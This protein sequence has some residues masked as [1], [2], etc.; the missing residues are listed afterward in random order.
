[1]VVIYIEV[2]NLLKGH[3]IQVMAIPSLKEVM[4]KEDI[5]IN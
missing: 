1:M 5:N 2:T 4:V 3:I